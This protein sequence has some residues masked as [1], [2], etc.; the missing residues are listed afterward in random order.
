MLEL[1]KR[2]ERT[3]VF[4][5]MEEQVTGIYTVWGQP[6][7]AQKV[8]WAISL[9]RGKGKIAVIGSTPYNCKRTI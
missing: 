5:L 9:K 3:L 7:S 8:I 1:W 2:I 4:R 6:S